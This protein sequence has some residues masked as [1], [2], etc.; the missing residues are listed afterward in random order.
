MSKMRLM[1]TCVGVRIKDLEAMTDGAEEITYEELA[2]NCDL[3]DIEP[4]FTHPS[5]KEEQFA[6]FHKS[7]YREVPCYYFKHSEIEYIF[8]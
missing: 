3:S 4:L 6:S 5:L 1:L 7:T 2:K 8:L